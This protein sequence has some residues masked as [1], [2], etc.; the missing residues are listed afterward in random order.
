MNCRCGTSRRD[1]AAAAAV[2]ITVTRKLCTGETSDGLSGGTTAATADWY[3]AATARATGVLYP[4]LSMLRGA[5]LFGCVWQRLDA[6]AMYTTP[7][8]VCKEC[9]LKCQRAEALVRAISQGNAELVQVPPRM[10]RHL[11]CCA[12]S[13]PPLILPASATSAS[14]RTPIFLWDFS[15]R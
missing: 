11:P 4:V 5:L 15:R 1:T 2:T 9:S 7:V 13:T 3:F 6:I 14:V 12:V 10:W 8:R